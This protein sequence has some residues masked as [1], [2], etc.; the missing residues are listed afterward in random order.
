MV[1]PLGLSEMSINQRLKRI[2]D[3]LGSVRESSYIVLFKKPGN[4]TLYTEKGVFWKKPLG[5]KK[6]IIV[7]HWDLRNEINAFSD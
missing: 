6:K 5:F 1:T 7:F 2:E 3:R 4:D